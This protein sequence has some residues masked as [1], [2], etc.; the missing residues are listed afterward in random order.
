MLDLSHLHKLGMLAV[1]D[2]ELFLC[3]LDSKLPDCQSDHMS[4]ELCLLVS[5]FV[6]AYLLAMNTHIVKVSWNYGNDI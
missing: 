6:L 4:T 1:T 3:R 5:P 2:T